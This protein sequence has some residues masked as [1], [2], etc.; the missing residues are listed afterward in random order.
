MAIK[1]ATKAVPVVEQEVS[2]K[3][4]DMADRIDRMVALKGQMDALGDVLKPLA[5]EMAALQG[6]LNQIVE[7]TYAADW[8]GVLKGK[9]GEVKVGPKATK[10]TSISKEALIEILGPDQYIVLA[11]MKIGDIR[12]YLTP[13]QIADVLTEEKSGPRSVKIIPN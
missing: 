3:T 8:G 2:V 9:T 4:T 11:E 7:D 1:F 12:K 10:V 5:T 6:E 13:P